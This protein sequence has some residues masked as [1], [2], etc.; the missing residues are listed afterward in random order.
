VTPPVALLRFIRFGKV[1]HAAPHFVVRDEDDL[2]VLWMPIGTLMKRPVAR[3]PIRGQADGDWEMYDH[4]WHTSSQL[5]LIPWG[6]AHCIELL[7]N[8]A[9]EF[10]G[11]Y[12]NIQEP[13]RR[14]PTG[15]E[16]D[17]LILDIRVQPDETWAWKDEDELEEA[18]RLGRF[19]EAEAVEIRA[20]GERVI[21]ERP[22][23]TGW[24]DWRPDPAW[25]LPQLAEGW[26]VV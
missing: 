2:V 16:T 24:E 23:P 6:R 10:A 18:V 4:L 12:V 14:T 3:G 25:G 15:F 11:W 1:R 13:L 21:E 5:S 26:D 7:W 22:W 8:Q 20:E 17:D 19:T 9:D